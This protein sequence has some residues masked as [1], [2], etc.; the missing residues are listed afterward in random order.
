M[1]QLSDDWRELPPNPDPLD[2]LGYDLAELDFI[3]TSTSGGAE[4]LV[5]PTDDD[6][7]REDAFLVVDKASVVDLTDRA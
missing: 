6:M 3:P 2:D 7:L 4:V 5:L 1:R